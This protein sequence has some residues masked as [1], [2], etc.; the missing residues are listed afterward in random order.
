MP[1]YHQQQDGLSVIR[2]E[3]ATLANYRRAK[4][5]EVFSVDLWVRATQ[6]L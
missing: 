5:L 6:L 2:P 4:Q 1:S 3:D